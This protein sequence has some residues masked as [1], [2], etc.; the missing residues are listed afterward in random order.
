MSTFVLFVGTILILVGFHE[1]GHFVAAKLVRIGVIEF[2][3]GFGPPLRTWKR[4]KTRYSLRLFPFGGY[5]RLAGE[6]WDY[7]DFPAEETYYGRPAWAR[8]LVAFLGPAFNLLLALVLAFG[9]FWTIG[10]PRLR[11]A[12]LVHEKPAEKALRV[13]DVILAVDGKPVWSTDQIGPLIQAK[14]PEPVRFQIQREGE[15]LEV[16]IVPVYSEEDGRYIVGAYFLPQVVLAELLEV[17]ALTPLSAAGF[18]SGDRIVS[19]CGKPVGSYLELRRALAEGCREVLVQRGEEFLPL[20]LPNNAA[21]V[22]E[23]GAWK[24]LPFAYG[25]IGPRRSLALAAQQVGQALFLVAAALQALVARRIPAGEAISGP[26]GIAAVLAEGI[27]AGPLVLVLLVAVISVNIAL[28][29]L[30]PLPALDGSRLLFALVELLTR[31]RIPPRVE[32]LVHTLG[33]VLLL[34]LLVL[35]TARDLLRLFG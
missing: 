30:L 17:P 25:A 26:V 32:T 28:F 24:A 23:S 31:R 2:A 12:G 10:L 33:F 11:V 27:A 19:A 6:S 15:L 20:D 8:L 1:L 22:L 34:G 9:A 16:H 7:G 18:R 5:V 3:I 35:I 13:G 14:A 4:G 21:Q 29:N